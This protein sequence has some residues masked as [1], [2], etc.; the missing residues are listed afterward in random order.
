MWQSWLGGLW[1]ELWFLWVQPHVINLTLCIFKWGHQGRYWLGHGVHSFYLHFSHSITD[2]SNVIFHG[3]KFADWLLRLRQYVKFCPES[4]KVKTRWNK[5][6]QNWK[7]AVW[8]WVR[9]A[10]GM[11]VGG[12]CVLCSSAISVG[13]L[14]KFRLEYVSMTESYTYL[15]ARKVQS[16]TVYQV[17]I[18]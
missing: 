6:L 18:S 9:V 12:N 16:L 2:L 15:L 13:L 7:W 4:V 17:L 1:F 8:R 5:W 10:I 14:R 11:R 3:R